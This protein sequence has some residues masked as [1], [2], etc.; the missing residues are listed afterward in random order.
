MNKDDWYL[1]CAMTQLNQTVGRV[2][3]HSEDYGCVVLLDYR[4][5]NRKINIRFSKWVQEYLCL[6]KSA[7]GVLDSIDDFFHGDGKAVRDKQL[8]LSKSKKK[9][10]MMKSPSPFTDVYYILSEFFGVSED[11][12]E[13]KNSLNK[14]DDFKSSIEILKRMDEQEFEKKQQLSNVEINLI[15]SSQDIDKL[16]SVSYIKDSEC[17]KCRSNKLKSNQM[18]PFHP[19]NQKSPTNSS[20]S[21]P[22]AGR[23]LSTNSQS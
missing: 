20:T 8:Q 22:C 15:P 3:R 12:D 5:R 23:A 13:F 19:I 6:D 9:K 16:P 10:Q 21:A 2:I 11:V 7:E 1:Q 4:F 18:S 14:D 17:V